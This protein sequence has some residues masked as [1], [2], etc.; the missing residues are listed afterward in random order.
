MMPHY[1]EKHADIMNGQN[2]ETKKE[3]MQRF[4]KDWEVAKEI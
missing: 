4:D 1:T 2:E 3:W